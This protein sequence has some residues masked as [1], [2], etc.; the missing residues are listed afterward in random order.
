VRFPGDFTGVRSGPVRGSFGRT[1]WGCGVKRS[2]LL[3]AA[4]GTGQEGSLGPDH[5]E[6]GDDEE[7]VTVARLRSKL[8]SAVENEDYLEAARL[9]DELQ[10]VQRWSV[11]RRFGNDDAGAAATLGQAERDDAGFGLERR[12]TSDEIIL[13]RQPASLVLSQE[14]RTRDDEADDA[15]FY[16]KPRLTMHYDV[17]Y[18]TKLQGLYTERLQEG[19]RILDLG[20]SCA[21]LLPP[22]K[23]LSVWGVGMNMVEMEVNECLSHRMVLD[24]NASPNLP[25]LDESFDGVILSGVMPYLIEPES[26]LA[27]VI[28]VLTPAGVVIVSFS[29]RMWMSKATQ[30]WK[31]RGN[32]GRCQLVQECMRAAG[33]LTEPEMIVDAPFLNPVGQLLPAL[34]DQA[35]GD[36][37]L[38]VVAYKGFPPQG[39]AMQIDATNTVRLPFVDT[40]VQ[41]LKVTPFAAMYLIYILL[42]HS[43]H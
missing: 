36:P 31:S 34:R 24:L 30:A 43:L 19:S 17:Q 25:F 2:L 42:Q 3:M 39:W 33:G 9:K 37:F 26:V 21:S 41:A 10:Q 7:S 12:T 6:A 32:L 8:Q 27:E 11:K 28:R 18:A 22:E 4:G 13:A 38:A 40:T 29:D 1:G 14:E 5:Y 15:L 23:G 35:G 20:A 16:T